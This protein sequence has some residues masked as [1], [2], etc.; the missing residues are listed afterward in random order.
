M[1]IWTIGHTN[2]RTSGLDI[3]KTVPVIMK[4]T[5]TRRIGLLGNSQ[6]NK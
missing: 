5:G 2:S 6:Q 1:G 4:H 3:V